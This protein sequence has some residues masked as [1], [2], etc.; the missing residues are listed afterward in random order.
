MRDRKLLERQWSHVFQR[1]WNVSLKNVWPFQGTIISAKNFDIL[2]SLSFFKKIVRTS[3]IFKEA[4]RM[5]TFSNFFL[6]RTS[7]K[8]SSSVH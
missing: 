8:N 4:I 1:C 6:G 2:R 7:T 5:S 3:A